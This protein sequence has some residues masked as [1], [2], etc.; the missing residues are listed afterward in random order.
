MKIP[1][2]IVQGKTDLQV[3]VKDANLLSAAK[4]DAKLLI[5]EKMNHVL[6]ESDLDQQ[7]NMETYKNPDLKLKSGLTEELVCFIKAIK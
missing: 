5:I 3:P 1:V 2:L 6:K 7:K 4:P